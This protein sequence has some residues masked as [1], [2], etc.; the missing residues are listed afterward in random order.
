MKPSLLSARQ[1]AAEA[2]WASPY[3]RPPLPIIHPGEG[4]AFEAATSSG[5]HQKGR[6]FV[7]T[8]R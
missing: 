1:A 8:E 7:S 3:V 5:L 4:G 6:I 2:H